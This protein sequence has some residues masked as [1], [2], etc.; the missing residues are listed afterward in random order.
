MAQNLNVPNYPIAVVA[1]TKTY[2]WTHKYFDKTND[3]LVNV[4]STKIST[5]DTYWEVNI[6]HHQLGSEPSVIHQVVYC[7]IN[8]EFKSKDAIDINHY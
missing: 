2:R 1:G 7:L 4:D 3:A 5:M 6:S 8:G